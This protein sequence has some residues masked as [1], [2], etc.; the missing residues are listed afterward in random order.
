M[1]KF[2][3]TYEISKDGGKTWE[4][5]TWTTEWIGVATVLA[6]GDGGLWLFNDPKYWSKLQEAVREM[7][8]LVK[9]P[10]GVVRGA[11]SRHFPDYKWLK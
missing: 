7:R 2:D 8:K 9:N 5:L 11:I 10:I 3:V 6:D 4:T 1:A